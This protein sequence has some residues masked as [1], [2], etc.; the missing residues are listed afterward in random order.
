MVVVVGYVV[1]VIAGGVTGWAY[2]AHVRTLPYDASGGMYAGG[3]LL[4]S[5][6]ALL[7]VALVPTVLALWF[8]RRHIGFWNGV[9][10]ASIAFA[11]LGLIAVLAPL[12]WRGSPQSI[13]LM[14]VD[15]L[16]LS[17]LLGVP[18]WLGAFVLF[19]LVAPNPGIRRRI[20]VALAIE[21]VVGVCALVHWFVP[22]API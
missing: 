7:V 18:L 22:A 14:I 11:A 12:A 6:A 17:H 10:T 16:G 19:S 5:L 20:S 8:L 9:A 15:L 1:A 2:D 21:I 4:A 3:Q 13:G